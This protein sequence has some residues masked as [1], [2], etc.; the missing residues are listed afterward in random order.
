MNDL[1]GLVRCMVERVSVDDVKELGENG[2]IRIKQ[3]P[4][5]AT[6]AT[7]NATVAD[8]ERKQAPTV[9]A[10]PPNKDSSIT[11]LSDEN[12]TASVL[13]GGDELAAVVMLLDKGEEEEEVDEDYD[14][15]AEDESTDEEFEDDKCTD[16]R[17]STRPVEIAGQ[18][19]NLPLSHE[20]KSTS[21]IGWLEKKADIGWKIHE[22]CLQSVNTKKEYRSSELGKRY[23]CNAMYDAPNLSRYAAEQIMVI[24]M[25]AINGSTPNSKN[26]G[27]RWV[28]LTRKALSP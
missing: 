25:A 18:T 10:S 11:L 24:S 28:G 27:Q 5:P 2:E 13:S 14:P 8:D 4:P 1:K 21:A 3:P 12:V 16:F 20:L 6:S 26:S 9:A 22:K 19:L 17:W 15:E 7:T 23:Y